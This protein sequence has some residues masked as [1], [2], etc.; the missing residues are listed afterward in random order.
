MHFGII[1]I[2]KFGEKYIKCINTIKYAYASMLC[3]IH[4]ETYDNLKEKPSNY[5][6][7][8]SDYNKV[9]ECQQVEC[10][11][12][13]AHPNIHYEVI[14]KA[15]EKGKHVICEKPTFLNTKEI[16]E[17]ENLARE[18]R[19]TFIIN[20]IHL[21][22]PFIKELRDSVKDNNDF[23]IQSQGMGNGPIRTY[24]S[25]WDW[26]VHDVSLALFLSKNQKVKNAWVHCVKTFEKKSLYNIKIE[27]EN[28]SAII[29][30]GNGSKVK[31]RNLYFENNETKIYFDEND[32]SKHN[33][34]KFMIMKVMRCI[35]NNM[36]FSNIHFHKR[37]DETMW[38]ALT[39]L[40]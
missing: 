32:F 2:G 38:T 17:L 36:V 4:K 16:T 20:Y 31:R 7:W 22:Q 26:G 3:S 12:V 23:Y 6:L 10:V 40:K 28:G 1:G 5:H 14:K 39:N 24:S 8:T 29:Q 21:F 27:F 13:V 18:N 11:I 19:L 30:T 9:L 15:L 37:V 35:E 33:A 25:Y 34:L